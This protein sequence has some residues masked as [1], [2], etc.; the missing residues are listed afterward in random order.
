MEFRL[1]DRQNWKREE[2][3]VHYYE[4]IPCTYSMTTKLDITPLITR[5]VKLYPALLYSVSTIVNRHEEFRTAIDDK[6]RIGIIS[7]MT[8]CYT[9]FHK[10]TETFSTLWTEYSSDYAKFCKMYEKDIL[11]H[12]Q[13]KGLIAK[14]N[15]PANTFPVSM[16]PWTTFDGFN[17]NLKKGYDYLL[18]I[19]T[20]GKYYKSGESYYI[21]LSIQTHHSVCD[22]YHTC[23]FINQLQEILTFFPVI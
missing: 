14:P 17:L 2:Y 20:F 13:N 4:T 9:F 21:P 3:F 22:G 15:P 1:I 18:P 12:S 7:E 23:R 10:D 6:G 16:I 8:P 5:K 19:F 11:Q